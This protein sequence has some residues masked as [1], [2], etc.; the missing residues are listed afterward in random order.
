MSSRAQRVNDGVEVRRFDWLRVIVDADEPPSSMYGTH[1]PASRVM[2]SGGAPAPVSG[3]HVAMAPG[4]VDAHVAA[5]ERE[6]FTKGY[7]AGERAGVEAGAR[8][9]DAMLRRLAQTIEDIGGLRTTMV[10]Q[11]ERQMVQLA[12]MLAKR[13]VGRELSLDDDLVAAMAHVALERLGENTPA[14]IRLNP[15]DYAAIVSLR[16]EA[17][18]GTQVT[19]T[20][21]PSLPRGGCVVDSAFGRVDASVEA[22]LGELSR[23]LLGDP[24]QHAHMLTTDDVHL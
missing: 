13:V 14:T 12:L 18:E 11:T 7:A 16:G 9:A 24:H 22:Q 3:L 20:P 17:W 23:A 2:P 5:L 19:I 21:D 10:H 1:L 6:A 4:D 8:R 15:D